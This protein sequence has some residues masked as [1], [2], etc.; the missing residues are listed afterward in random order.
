MALIRF[1]S[2]A[3]V[4]SAMVDRVMMVSLR[5]LQWFQL[6][7]DR[8]AAVSRVDAAYDPPNLAAGASVTVSVTYPGA[9]PGDFV[10]GASFA[11]MTVGG[12]GTP[13]IRVLG[14]VESAGS[15]AVTFINVGAGAIDLDAGT[16]RV[17]LE[18]A[19]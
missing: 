9:T 17:Q 16:I 13:F 3:P 4:R 11:P 10:T 6:I 5:W 18:R 1:A 2:E 12:V 7:G 15:V 19:T 8:I 14:D